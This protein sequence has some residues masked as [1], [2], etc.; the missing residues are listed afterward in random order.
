MAATTTTRP[1]KKASAK[2]SSFLVA[3]NREVRRIAVERGLIREGD[4]DRA[5]SASI[6]EELLAEAKRQTGGESDAELI[7]IALATLAVN[8]NFGEWLIAQRG[9][10]PKDF[11]TSF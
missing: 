4:K 9:R 6:N 11:W 3:E 2:P 10:L 1:R 8:D 5:I 7:E